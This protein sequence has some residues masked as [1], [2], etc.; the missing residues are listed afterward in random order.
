LRQVYL[1]TGYDWRSYDFNP[2]ISGFNR[3]STGYTLALGARYDL[4]GI[5]FADAFAGYREQDYDDPRLAA[6]RGPTGG[7]KLT[8][9][10][11]RLTTITG[12][13]TRDVRETILAN[14]SG[15]FATVAELRVDHELRRFLLLDGVLSYE[16]DD[17]QGIGRTDDYYVAGISAKYLINRNLWISP[18]YSYRD[19]SS[20]ITGASFDEHVFLVHLSAHI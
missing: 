10:V 4:T 3:N 13:L 19:R 18:G 12:S 16:K 1:L 9:N 20:N 5:L 8:W 2:D 15:Y 14:S 11:T 6:V 17:F 7:A